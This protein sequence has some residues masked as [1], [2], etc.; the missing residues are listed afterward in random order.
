MQNTKQQ[1]G[2]ETFAKQL[3]LA[4]SSVLRNNLDFIEHLTNTIES[5]NEVQMLR[6]QTLQGLVY[7]TQMSRI[8]DEELF[9][10]CLDYWHFFAQDIMN[11]QRQ[12]SMNFAG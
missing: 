9:K 12:Y 10:I 4:I 3:A 2:F 5:N 6:D 11:K 7:L 8:Q 1:T